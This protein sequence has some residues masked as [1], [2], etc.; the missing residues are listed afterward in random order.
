MALVAI[1]SAVGATAQPPDSLQIFGVR[2]VKEHYLMQQGD[3]AFNVVD[4]NIQWPDS[5]GSDSVT[6]LKRCITA[7]LLKQDTTNIRYAL[8]IF[9]NSC[10]TP[11]TGQLPFLPDDDRFCY[12]TVKGRVRSYEPGRWICYE[13]L[14]KNEPQKRS[15]VR[16]ADFYSIITYDI[17]NHKILLPEHILDSKAITAGDVDQTFYDALLAPLNDD[18]YF[19]MTNTDVKGVWLKRE[20][21]GLHV[22]SLTGDG[23]VTYEVEMGY[24]LVMPL[25]SREAKKLTR[26]VRKE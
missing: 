23:F 26:G 3:S 14:A 1:F 13:L 11:V 22:D 16:A 25:L 20:G 4:V 10:G 21:V 15:R 5:L 6:I 9:N 8:E 18:Q 17:R 19:T 24:D 7:S 2:N 12:I